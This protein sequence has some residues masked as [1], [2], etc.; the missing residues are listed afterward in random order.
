MQA[1]AWKALYGTYFLYTYEGEGFDW[2]RPHLWD[3]LFSPHHGL[4]NW[5]PALLV[6]FAGFV[7]WVVVTPRRTEATCFAVSLLLTVYVNSAWHC[8]WFGDSF[9][10]R[11]YEGCTLFAMLGFGWIL[12]ALAG[13]AVAFHIAAALGLLAVL[14]SMNLL[15]LSHD[16]PLS[17]GR[18]VPWSEKIEMTRR[19]WFPGL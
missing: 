13:R 3:S 6:G 14:W 15:W 18:P 1:F 4:F 16:G 5:H 11:A 7:V 17:I 8:W 12:R 9:G 2:L 10:G 19:Y